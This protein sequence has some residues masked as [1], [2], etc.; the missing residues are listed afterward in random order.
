[1]QRLPGL[2][3]AVVDDALRGAGDGDIDHAVADVVAGD[4]DRMGGG[5]AGGAGREG[6][7][8]DAVLDADVG[9]GGGADDAQQRQRMC[10]PLVVDEQVAIGGLVGG[11]A[12]GARADDAGG[13][14]RIGQR[15]FEAGHLHCLGGGGGGEPRIAVGE[16]DQLVALEALEPRLRIEVLDLGRDEDLEVVERKAADRADAGLA[17]LQPSPE[18]RHVQSDRRD[19]AHA[20]HHD[21]ARR[22]CICHLLHTFEDAKAI[23]PWQWQ[24]SMLSPGR[25]PSRQS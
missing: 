11:E 6:R 25:R 22:I 15:P 16:R 24:P 18:F 10:R 1:M 13:A 8:L 21:A 7:S 4:A 5:R 20:G 14:I 3:R 12:A 2:H 19:H 23:T 9:R 17:A